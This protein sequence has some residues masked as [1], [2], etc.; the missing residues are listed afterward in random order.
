MK[1]SFLATTKEGKIKKGILK[2]ANKE[3]LLKELSN[4]GLSIISFKKESSR[5]KWLEISFGGVSSRDKLFFV[6]H[7]SV[8]MKAGLTVGEALEVLKDQAQGK[9]KKIIADILT[10][11]RKG[12]TL[13]FGLSKYPRVFSLLSVNLIDAGE[14][15]GTLEQNLRY[16]SIHLEKN[17]ELRKKIKG[18]MM[19]PVLV[20]SATIG[21]SLGLATLVLPKI[22]KFYKTLN[23]ELPLLTRGLLWVANL[24]ANYGWW[25]S[26]GLILGLLFL[27]WLFR[28]KFIRPFSHRLFLILP[29]VSRLVRQVQLARFSRVL[30]TLI[31]S[32][33]PI[34]RSLKITLKT[35]GNIIYQKKISQILKAVDRGVPIS[36]TMAFFERDFPKIFSRMIN[37]G[38]RTGELD[39]SLLYLA[40]FYETE[41]DN[42]TKNLSNI[43]EPIL[44]IF[45]GILVGTVVLSIISPIYQLIGTLRLHP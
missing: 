1:Y 25:I 44:L 42:T 36:E 12:N 34:D 39:S 30:G 10:L 31:K 18:A 4:R 6:K 7:L 5:K 27:I 19:Y 14:A 45:V 9:F 21:I 37:V 26:G 16:L 8:M 11:V 43:L 20:L 33:L 17:E 38:E 32:G 35:T 24:F 2:A 15:S 3:K 29:I 28:Q 22:T 40:E 23:V 41:V 13:S